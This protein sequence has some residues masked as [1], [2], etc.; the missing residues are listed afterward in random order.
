MKRKK[1]VHAPVN[2]LFISASPQIC[3]YSMAAWT[4][5]KK[6]SYSPGLRLVAARAK[7]GGTLEA[8]FSSSWIAIDMAITDPKSPYFSL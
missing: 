3:H 8:R 2:F 7:I 6:K 1:R 5:K 4:D